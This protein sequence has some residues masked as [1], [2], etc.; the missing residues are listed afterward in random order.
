MGV[1]MSFKPLLVI[2]GR[3]LLAAHGAHLPVAFNVLFKFALVIVGRE[4]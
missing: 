3:E 2:V 4:H 1:Y